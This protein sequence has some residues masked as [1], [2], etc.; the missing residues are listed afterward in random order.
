VSQDLLRE[1]ATVAEA[2]AVA[3][4][5][6]GHD[7][8]LQAVCDATKEL[9]GA[10]ACSIALVEEQSDEIV[11]RVAS[12]AGAAQVLGLRL[13]LGRGVAG[14]VVSS[15]MPIRVALIN[16]RGGDFYMA[17]SGD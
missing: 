17:T 7:E 15:G 1:L 9:F 11:Y 12:G 6:A 10:A 8:L 14:W 5:P 16:P 2:T 13:P 4:E 3:L